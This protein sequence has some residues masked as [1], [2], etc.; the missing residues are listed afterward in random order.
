MARF[1]TGGSALHKLLSR[2][3][4]SSAI[5]RRTGLLADRFDHRL[6]VAGIRAAVTTQPASESDAGA[7]IEVLAQPLRQ[8]GI[9]QQLMDLLKEQRL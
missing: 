2:L 7:S 3:G 5:S 8:R 4:L 1:T 9:E 6:E